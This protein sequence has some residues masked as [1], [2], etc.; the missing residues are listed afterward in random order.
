MVH[1]KFHLEEQP[2]PDGY[3]IFQDRIAVAGLFK[4]KHAGMAFCRGRQWQL[5][6]EREAS[7]RHDPNAIRIFGSRRG[8]FIKWEKLLGYVPAE[9]AARIVALQLEDHVRPRLL[10]TYIG[11]GGLVE[12][13]FQLTGPKEHAKAYKG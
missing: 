6:F 13:M 8:W 7:N 11:N 9:Q 12:I 10:K 3:Q 4:R 2:I 1:K 5:R